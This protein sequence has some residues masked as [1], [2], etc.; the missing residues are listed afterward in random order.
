MADLVNFGQIWEIS[1]AFDAL[2]V[3]E[4]LCTKWGLK[5]DQN[6]K[7]DQISEKWLIF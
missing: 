3:P 1:M 6:K 7:Y 4:S 2:S 5:P